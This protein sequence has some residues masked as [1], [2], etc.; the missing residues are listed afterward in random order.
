MADISLMHFRREYLSGDM[1]EHDLLEDPHLQFL[2]W[3]EDA[4]RSGIDDPNAM[5]LAT[6]DKSGK[7]TA[8]IVLLK[9]ARPEGLVFV[10]N[11]ESR[12]GRDLEENPRAA[13]LFF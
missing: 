8:R 4:M 9:D 7:P 12:K 10:T 5:S 1:L 11:F 2:V 13:A 6:A 3:L